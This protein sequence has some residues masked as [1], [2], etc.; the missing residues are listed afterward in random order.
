MTSP[1]GTW[2][3]TRM[4]EIIRRAVQNQATSDSERQDMEQFL[5]IPS[6][7]SVVEPRP[8]SY[9]EAPDQRQATFLPL[10]PL[11]E[12]T[13]DSGSSIRRTSTHGTNQ[14]GSSGLRTSGKPSP[15]G[16]PQTSSSGSARREPLSATPA[17]SP[18]GSA[19]RSVR[20]GQQA[21]AGSPQA[22]FSGPPRPGRSSTTPTGSPQ[23]ASSGPTQ[24]G[25][26][27]AD[28][29]VGESDDWDPELIL[30]D[31]RRAGDGSNGGS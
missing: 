6:F 24:R 8:P 15:T 29:S 26:F 25:P 10:Q 22:G 9:T 12:R 2:I 31:P 3:H 17:G 21:T 13:S 14:T 30:P 1:N 18:R 27:H 11:P 19:S 16:S 20:R 5:G 23:T 28:T 7:T 4:L